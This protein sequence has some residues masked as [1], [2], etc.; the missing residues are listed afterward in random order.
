MER[1]PVCQARLRQDPVCP[2]CRADLS[3][4]LAIET[5]ADVWL[6]QAFADLA[7]GREAQAKHAVEAS[8]RLKHGL[9]A[10]RLRIF[11]VQRLT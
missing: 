3:K 11:L 5:E 8:L 1:C 4:L 6:R 10:S 2:R 7:E 9:L